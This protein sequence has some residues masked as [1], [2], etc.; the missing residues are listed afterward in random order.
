MA[1]KIKTT[2]MRISKDLLN[3]LHSLQK[4]HQGLQGVID[5]LITE[6]VSGSILLRPET[7]TRL[8]DYR[9]HPRETVDDLIKAVL[10]ELEKN[11]SLAS[12]EK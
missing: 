11:I 4:S 12:K 3:R 10:D 8:E 7:L 5:D 2:S 6:H 1:E 9:T